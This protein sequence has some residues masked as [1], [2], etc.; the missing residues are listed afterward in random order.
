MKTQI[1]INT[2]INNIE[3][4]ILD[5]LQKYDFS[6]KLYSL[7]KSYWV[8]FEMLEYNVANNYLKKFNHSMFCGYFCDAINNLIKQNFI[9][10]TKE[11]Q[12]V[13]GVLKGHFI[14]LNY[15]GL[16][17]DYLSNKN[18]TLENIT[19]HLLVTNIGIC[20]AGIRGILEKLVDLNQIQLLE[21]T[22]IDLND[23]YGN[24]KE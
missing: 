2:I 14:S 12:L 23:L 8:D 15:E 24:I 1:Q 20:P 18:E 16:I 5:Y 11:I 7:R 9:Q 3:H 10:E 22:N 21:K 19:N 4:L 6:Y 13:S 17:L